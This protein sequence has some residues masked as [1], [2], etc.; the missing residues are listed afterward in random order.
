MG[1]PLITRTAGA[2]V[3]RKQPARHRH[4][5]RFGPM[6]RH[7]RLPGGR[8]RG[9]RQ[10]SRRERHPPHRPR[11]KL[12][13]GPDYAEYGGRVGDERAGLFNRWMAEEGWCLRD[14][15]VGFRETP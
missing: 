1:G 6:G 2:V 7:D 14:I 5:L 9:D 15:P 11:E 8:S 13:R 10:Q 4:L 12:C 3:R